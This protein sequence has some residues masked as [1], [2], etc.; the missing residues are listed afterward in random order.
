MAESTL[1]PP[2][3]AGSSRREDE[4]DLDSRASA[5]DSHTDIGLRETLAVIR[6]VLVTFWP[7]APVRLT[8]KT[9]LQMGALGSIALLLPWQAKA[10]IDHVVLGNPIVTTGYPPYL[11]PVLRT[12]DGMAPLEILFWL[13][14]MAIGMVLTLGFYASGGARDDGVEAGMEQGHDIA[15]ATENDMNQGFS[16]NGGL[17]GYVEFTLQLRLTQA[18]NHVLRSQLFSRL[19]ALSMTRLEDQRI[20]DSVYR[21]MYDTP[22][23]TTIF[24]EVVLT[25]T[26]SLTILHRRALRLDGR[27]SACAGDLLDIGI[28]LPHLAHHQRVFLARHAPPRPSSPSLR[29]HH[30]QHRRGRYG[31]HPRRAEPGRQQ[32]G[33]EPIRRRLQ[34]VVQAPSR[35][36]PDRHHRRPTRRLHQR[37][38]ANGGIR[39]H[40]LQRHRRRADA[41]RL[42]R[43]VRFLG[44]D[45]RAGVLAWWSVDPPARQC[46]RHAARVRAYGSAAGGRSGRLSFGAHSRRHRGAQRRARLSRRAPRA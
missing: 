26:G 16:H 8:V 23:V 39:G 4:R 6:R 42:R 12:L 24:Y 44:H 46:R 7:L 31:Q 10:I 37:R 17:W 25:P 13:T 34:G 14:A 15:T 3:A 21:V 35:L 9:L 19:A 22:A 5:L 2:P 36:S 33:E 40:Q 11:H 30:H 28:D 32:E 29:R 18:V 1:T 43:G 45:A 38:V 41:R 20:G 27:L